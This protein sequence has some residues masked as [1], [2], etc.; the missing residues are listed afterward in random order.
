[1]TTPNVTMLRDLVLIKPRP[2]TLNKTADGLI[3][4]GDVDK[5]APKR[6]TVIAAGPGTYDKK[7][8]FRP[9]KITAGD[10]IL[11]MERD[12]I[13]TKIEGE[14]YFVM[15]QEDIILKLGIERPD[16]FQTVVE[17]TDEEY[18]AHTLRRTLIK[19]LESCGLKRVQDMLNPTES[20]DAEDG[21][22]KVHATAKSYKLVSEEEILSF[23]PPA[24]AKAF[25]MH[26][27]NY[28]YK[29]GELEIDP[30]TYQPTGRR[31]PSETVVV[32]RLAFLPRA[33]VT[34]G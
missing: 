23:T 27:S 24:D 18:V 12:L 25:A 3:L 22:E 33:D 1:M 2:L 5:M 30:V 15:K 16:P 34:L 13:P 4:P 10:Q 31:L 14:D 26:V 7:G 11:Y 32:V 9:N 21:S 20:Y 19:H 6:A 28:A 17:M 8:V 29:T